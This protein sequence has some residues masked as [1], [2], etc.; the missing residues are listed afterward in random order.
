MSSHKSVPYRDEIRLKLVQVLQ[1]IAKLKE[2]KTA[3]TG[4]FK[5]LKS[6]NVQIEFT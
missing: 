5:S 4:W 1:V 2:I 6:P 3:V